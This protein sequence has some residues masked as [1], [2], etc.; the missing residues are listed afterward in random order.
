MGEVSAAA[1]ASSVSCSRDSYKYMWSPATRNSLGRWGDHRTWLLEGSGGGGGGDGGEEE[2]TEEDVEEG[3][4][5]NP[6][7]RP[8]YMPPPVPTGREAATGAAKR[9]ADM[10]CGE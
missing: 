1:E 5:A 9:E 6:E 7:G 4:A 10:D 8:P 3:A 2:E